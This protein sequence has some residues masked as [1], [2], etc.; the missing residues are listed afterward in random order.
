MC[1][2]LHPYWVGQP[3]RIRAVR[4]AL[5]YVLSHPGV[6]LDHRRRH[7]RL[8]QRTPSAADRGTPRGAGGSQWL[9]IPSQSGPAQSGSAS[10]SAQVRPQRPANTPPVNEHRR[11]GM[12]QT[13]HAFRTLTEAPRFAWPDGARIALTVTLVLDYWELDPPKAAKLA[14]RASSRPWATSFPTG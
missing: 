13:H 4:A 9:S 8:V 14:I 1:I 6:W 7:R 11:P 10:G 5:E 12:D 2:A 3:H